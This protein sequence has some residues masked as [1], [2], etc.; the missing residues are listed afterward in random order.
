MSRGTK[1]TTF[2][3]PADVRERAQ[4]RA[5]GDGITVTAVVV[6][7]LRMYGDGIM[8][9]PPHDPEPEAAAAVAP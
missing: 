4:Q 7:A 6:H 9:P 2:R 5:T 1:T 8:P 3:I